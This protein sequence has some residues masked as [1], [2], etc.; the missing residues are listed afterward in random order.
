MPLP[1]QSLTIFSSLVVAL[2]VSP[3]FGQDFPTKSIRMATSGAGGGNDFV[4]RLVAPALTA[5]LGQQVIVDNR[6]GLIAA[7]LVSRA[8]ADGYTLLVSSNSMWIG[9]LLRKTP[10]DPISDFSAIS[11]TTRAPL[12]LAVHPSHQVSSVKELIALAKSKPGE[13]NYASTTPGGP[14]HISMELL[15]SMAGVNI[16]RISYKGGGAAITGLLS[17]EVGMTIDGG[18]QLMPHIKSG[19]LKALAVTTA[20][21]SALAPGLPPVAASGLPGFE[22]AQLSGVLA[23]AK[24]PKP[25]INRLNQEIVRALNQPDVK[26][27]FFNSGAEAASSSPEQFAAAVRSEMNRLGKVIKEAGIKSD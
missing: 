25:V 9:P 17:G 5:G 13:L 15:K 19:K 21:P 20:Q 18:S 6:G 2:G 16:V 14:S 22:A 10:Y 27:K 24:T 23:P 1:R 11:T 8:A 7:E 3:V 4:A 26:E 12:I